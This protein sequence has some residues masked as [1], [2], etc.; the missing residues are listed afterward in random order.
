MQVFKTLK[1]AKKWRFSAA[2]GNP[3]FLEGGEKL[4][5]LR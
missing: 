1:A 5:E 2:S 3:N 4:V